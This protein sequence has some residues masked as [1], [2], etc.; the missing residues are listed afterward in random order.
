MPMMGGGA[1]P[2]FG[3]I[4]LMF[5]FYIVAIVAITIYASSLTAAVH[6][7]LSG[8]SVEDASKTFS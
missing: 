4:A 6:L 7:Q 1:M 3:T 5:V 8:R 2:G